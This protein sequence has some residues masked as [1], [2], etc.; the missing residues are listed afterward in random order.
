MAKGSKSRFML[1]LEY[2]P[3]Y[4]LYAFIHKLSLKTAYAL[5]TALFKVLYVVAWRLR[6]RAKQ[7]LLHSGV[8]KSAADADR[9]ARLS[10]IEFGKLLVEIVKMNQEY[11]PAKVRCVGPAEAVDAAYGPNS[12]NFIVVTAHYGNWEVA[13]TAFCDKSRHDMVSIMR[14]FSNPLI[15]ELILNHRRGKHHSVVPKD[16]GGMRQLVKALRENKL[17]T[18]LI[19]QHASRKEGVETVFFGQPCRTH[20]TPALLHLKTGVPI[21]PE[22]TRRAGDNF[23]FELV[24]GD[25]IIYQ[26][27]GDKEADVQAITQLCTTALEKIIAERPEQWLWVHR[28][29]LN[30]NR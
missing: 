10:F 13:G 2:I 29:W 15:G 4:C 21:L 17:A 23:E 25:P 22:I 16:A 28:R 11:D 18:V 19:D 20:K 24:V 3:F 5:S 14:A 6:R 27:T 9:I 1:Y 8:A 12:R 7:H 26:P 30:I